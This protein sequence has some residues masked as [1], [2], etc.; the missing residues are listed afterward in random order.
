LQWVVLN[1]FGT[2]W[3][4]TQSTGTTGTLGAVKQAKIGDLSLSF[5]TSM[6]GAS[7]LITDSYIT[8]P[9]A[10]ILGNYKRWYA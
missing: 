7:G 9:L 3:D 5:D 6:G 2:I 4:E 1:L 8:S 10:N